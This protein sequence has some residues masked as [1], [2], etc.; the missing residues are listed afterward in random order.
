MLLF[1]I[2]PNQVTGQAKRLSVNE[3]R[4]FVQTCQLVPLLYHKMPFFQ[5][6]LQTVAFGCCSKKS[7]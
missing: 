4:F 7:F 5:P 6:F 1:I 3:A 2:L